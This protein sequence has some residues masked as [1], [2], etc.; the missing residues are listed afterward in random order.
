MIVVLL[1]ITLFAFI[2][3]TFYKASQNH[4]QYFE[5][6]NLKYASASYALRF[7]I[8]IVSGKYDILEL[9]DRFY[10]AFPEEP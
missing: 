5:D 8:K 7:L 6:R 4:A 1:L 2:A 9:S 10:N 3:Y